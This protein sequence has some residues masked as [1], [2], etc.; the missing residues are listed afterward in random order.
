MSLSFI[1]S[2][3]LRMKTSEFTFHYLQTSVFILICGGSKSGQKFLKNLKNFL[4]A[5]FNSQQKRQSLPIEALS[6][7]LFNPFNLSIYS[8]YSI[9]SIQSLLSNNLLNYP[10]SIPSIIVLTNSPKSLCPSSPV[11]LISPCHFPIIS[12]TL[13]L[14]PLQAFLTSCLFHS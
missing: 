2:V 4:C 10:S 14:P 6:K 11:N 7:S 13:T 1:S 3:L 5:Q 9:Q 8:I 12:P